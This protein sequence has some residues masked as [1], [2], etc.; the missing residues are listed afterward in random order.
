MGGRGAGCTRLV[1]SMEVVRDGMARM[2]WG[3]GGF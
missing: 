3:R 1:G 2:N